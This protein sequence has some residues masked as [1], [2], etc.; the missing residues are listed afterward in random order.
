MMSPTFSRL[1]ATCCAASDASGTCT[2]SP[3]GRQHYGTSHQVRL[4]LS[5]PNLKMP[6]INGDILLREVSR[7]C[8]R[9]TRIILSAT[10]CV[11]RSPT[12]G[13][14]HTVLTQPCDVAALEHAIAAGAPPGPLAAFA[15][16]A[17]SGEARSGVRGRA[18]VVGCGQPRIGVSDAARMERFSFR[19]TVRAPIA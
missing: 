6:G 10:P 18:S 3:V 16:H 13:I 14:A 17:E 12:S 8:S 4:T 7:R 2:S 9:T 15:G 19:G 1:C 11:P 5:S